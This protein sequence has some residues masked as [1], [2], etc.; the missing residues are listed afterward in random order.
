MR[1]ISRKDR[2]FLL[3]D[4]V[5]ADHGLSCQVQEP[6][7]SGRPANSDVRDGEVRGEGG[8]SGEIS[9]YFINVRELGDV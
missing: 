7:A 6:W 2:D 5:R 3:L 8:D 1:G 9:R 4:D